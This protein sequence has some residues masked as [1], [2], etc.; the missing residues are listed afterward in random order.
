MRFGVAFRLLGALLA[1]TGFG[2]AATVAALYAFSQY[3]QGFDR[4][5]SSSLPVLIAASDIVA[6]SQALAANARNLAVVDS[7]F[8][9]QAVSQAVHKQLKGLADVGE[10][11]KALAPRT[12]GLGR[13][14]Q[15][16]G[17]LQNNL[18]QLEHLVGDR[19]DADSSAAN[20]MLRLRGLAARVH[21]A[22]AAQLPIIVKG[23][24]Q[25]SVE[26]F[27]AWMA[28]ADEAI[29]VMLSTSTA[30]SVT[31]LNRL[32]ADF[33]GLRGRT[34]AALVRLPE[35]G[36]AFAPLEAALDQYGRAIPNVFDARSAQL[37]S[38]SAAWGA[39]LETQDVSAEFVAS[40][41]SVF[42]EVQ[43]HT[44]EQ[45][46]FFAES[47]SQYSRLFTSISA[48]SL[49]GSAGVF[50]YIVRSIIFRL[51][52]LSDGMRARIDGRNVP[53]PTSGTDE[54]AE[55][56]KATQ[57]FITSIEERER[58]LRERTTE[59]TQ[60]VE[61]LHALGDV[62]QAV[63]STLDLETV[64]ATIIAKAVQLS[65]T[66]AGT[67]YVFDEASREF[68]LRSTYG[69]DEALI[70]GVKGAPIHMGDATVVDQAAVLRM[71][72]YIA[73][74]QHDD[75]SR[76]H[77]AILRAG[78]RALLTIPLLGADRIVGALVVRRKEPGEFPKRTV[79]LLQ[80]FG[81]QSA[82]AIQNARLFHEIEAKGRQIA[83]AS[84][85]KSQFVANMS[86]E[87]RTPL[88]AMLGY[89][90]LLKENIYGALPEK[91]TP[92]IARVQ[93]NG[94]HLLG[95]I[96]TVLDIAKIESGQFEL[97][98]SEY[99]LSSM[100]ETV[101]VATESLAE[102]KKLALKTDVA[103]GLP[104]G[105]GDEQR[106][107][108]VLLNLVGNAIKFTDT[109]EVLI[110]ARAA[111]GRF[112]VAV[113]DTGPG[114]PPEERDKVFEKFHQIDNS[115][116]RTKGGTGLGLAI[117]KDIVEMHGGRIWVESILGQGATFSI[118]VPVRAV[119]AGGAA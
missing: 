92:I 114:I 50:F 21:A 79:D 1:I 74:V 85:H 40:A 103:K 98:F 115:S 64:L 73:D 48:L 38:A 76:V 43:S 4:I 23:G 84:Q 109:G 80:T 94:Q 116:T 89:A 29:A 7:H 70:A 31:R 57:F 90:E 61:E 24:S 53:I 69:M 88:A 66:E 2:F 96:N 58:A 44:R 65:G 18:K 119:A 91:A 60:S 97:N 102:G 28:A 27:L 9:R 62:S 37:A 107:T 100:I 55:M 32:R 49:M 118:E 81:A 39:L 12:E 77:D 20:L 111:N 82:L 45:S 35:H 34:R 30:D 15:S 41:Q 16:H 83:I 87:L 17:L 71:P 67:I 104:H 93:S 11:I 72:V 95:L 117:A 113:S 10:R 63:N 78:F 26:A 3:R 101:R 52:K 42:Q 54:I 8:A 25:D 110:M 75:A 86:H 5:A 105:L 56:A 33:D 13:L 59:L 36:P 22:S 47:I 6:Q 99:A 68:R 108:Q 14:F 46:D 112:T 19:I 106:L 51:Q